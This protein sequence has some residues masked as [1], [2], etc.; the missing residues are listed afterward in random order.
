[1]LNEIVE[2]KSQP[3]MTMIFGK[4]AFGSRNYF[5]AL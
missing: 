2:L 5:V 4:Y 1:M 3:G